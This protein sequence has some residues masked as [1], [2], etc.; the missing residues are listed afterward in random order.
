[1]LHGVRFNTVAEQP[2]NGEEI[3]QHALESLRHFDV[4]QVDGG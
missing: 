4:G 3:E 2:L 1:L